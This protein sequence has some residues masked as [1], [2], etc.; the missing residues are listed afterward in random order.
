[1]EKFNLRNLGVNYTVLD[2]DTQETETINVISSDEL[3]AIVGEFV[4]EDYTTVSRH[5]P[6][7]LKGFKGFAPSP[8]HITWYA[9]RETN[10]ENM[11]RG[12]ISAARREGNRLVVTEILPSEELDTGFKT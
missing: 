10:H 8:Y 1:M 7:L 9:T 4:G 3:K 12:A 6:E 11:L 5:L 2:Q